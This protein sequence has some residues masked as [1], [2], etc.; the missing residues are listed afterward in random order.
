MSE[1]QP[2]TPAPTLVGVGTVR[3]N[4]AMGEKTAEIG[5]AAE[6]EEEGGAEGPRRGFNYW[7]EMTLEV[8]R[9]WLRLV[10]TNFC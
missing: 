4:I 10:C 9:P 2:P 6:G 1:S 7:G 8:Y 5:G 3:L